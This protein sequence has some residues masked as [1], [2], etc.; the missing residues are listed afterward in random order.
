[1]T[2]WMAAAA[3]AVVAGIGA[4]A[5]AQGGTLDPPTEPMSEESVQ[6]ALDDSES[7]Q[8]SD[9][10]SASESPSPTP[11]DEPDATPSPGA[12]EQVFGG[13]GGTFLASCDGTQV[14]IESWTPSQGWQV[15]NVESV[16][17]ADA[18]IEFESESDE[19][20]YSVR[21]VDGVPQL[22]SADDD[23]GDDSGDDG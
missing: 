16:P 14:T 7:N 20:E 15:S 18:E 12:G 17:A 19:E 9:D 10:A 6:Q 4:V 1:M 21:C 3:V 23:T 5:L 22:G 2:G 11:S 8:P 13:A